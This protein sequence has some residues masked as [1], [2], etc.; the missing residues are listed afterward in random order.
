MSSKFSPV[1]DRIRIIPRSDD[2]LDRNV[3][4]SGEVFYD[5]QSNSLRIYS[6]KDRGGF[7]LLTSGNFTQQIANTG[8]AVLEK[9]VTVGVDSVAGQA[10][11]VFYINGVEKPI[12]EFVRG[13][14][15]VFDQS[16]TTNANYAGLHHPLMF[17]TTQD[18]DLVEGGLHYDQ[19]TTDHGIVY[20]L[21]DDPVTMRNYTDKFKT[22]TTKKILITVQSN[23][24]DTLWY[25]CHFHTGQG[26][27]IN[28]SDPGTGSYTNLTDKPTI[29]ADLGDLTDTG[30]LLFDGAYGS[31]TGAPTIPSTILDLGITDGNVDQVLR[32]DGAGNF[33][34]V[35]QTGGSGS[36]DTFKT[37]VSDDGQ[38]IA[39]G[40]ST[41]NVLGGTNIAT[42][43]ATD[44]S[45]VTINLSTFSVDFLSDVDTTTTPPTSGQ[46]LK[47]DGAKWAPGT[48]A[49][50]GGAGT[51]ADT[52]DGFDG[53]YYLD[54]GNFTNTPTVATL[55]SFSIG[56]ELVASG[57]GAISY[58]NTTGVFRYTP[59]TAAGIGAITA[60]TN[61][62]TSA[63]VWAN[64]P[65]QYI[66]QSSVLQHQTA[67]SITSDQITDRADEIIFVGD[68]STGSSV[69]V[70]STIQFQGSGGASV[71][72]SN[73]VVT[74]AASGGGAASNSFATIAA[75]GNNIVAASATDTL[76]LTPGSNVT[77]GVDTGA[78]QIT[79][80]SSATGGATD[81]DD[82]QDVTTAGLKIDLV[83]EQAIVR[84]D[85]SADGL[86]G[87]RFTSHYTTL[88]P[89]IYAISGTTIAFN[90][91]SGTMGSHPFQIQDNT[92][93]QYDTGLVHY[94]PS[95]VKSTGSN[96]Q[97]KTSGTL[98][99]HVP[100]GISG[101]WRYQCTAHTAMVGTITVKA[102]NAL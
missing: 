2:F 85:V 6:G 65:N 41:L 24:P 45:N 32:T 37:V 53:T 76:I 27:Q 75:D 12:L 40:E 101:N 70:G 64:V 86:N 34:F 11:G 31:L 93:T 42:A 96:A 26:N 22:A 51:D 97:D 67:L 19:T 8:V 79:I 63:V 13:Y 48:D 92:G 74:I 30:S 78:K 54:Y 29:P 58:D 33:T 5:R 35:D 83:A 44:T 43:I 91:N 99:W 14:T 21:D 3:G 102:F 47:W 57:N 50:T 1:V 56:N 90:L 61:D 20:L 80:N 10:T 28:I 94:T 59:P 46:V 95:G 82:L 52:L 62:L 16:D 38:V 15:Y 36:G 98:Y 73:G 39:S 72:V 87:Y 9:T 18:G 68:D 66:T 89:T 55:S 7:T 17:S 60:E 71:Q 77:F 69:P 25:W 84:L 81:F 23:A 49:T 4:S 88:N 100:F